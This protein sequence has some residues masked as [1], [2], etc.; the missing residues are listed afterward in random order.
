MLK[1]LL[2][3][4]I[5]LTIISLWWQ[6]QQQP[7]SQTAVSVGQIKCDPITKNCV[8]KVDG[9]ELQ[10]FVDGPIHY[11]KP[12]TSKIQLRN[13]AASDVLNVSVEFAMKDMQMAAN[14]SVFTQQAKDI[15]QA[16]SLL[17]ICASGR[18]DWL[19]TVRLETKQGIWQS[20]FEFIVPGK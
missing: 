8:A 6:G 3:L 14:R 16:Q 7:L 18:K 5:L 11:L 4:A 1:W 9:G 12:F 13:I 2:L 19:A 15:W 17:P 10:W 20:G